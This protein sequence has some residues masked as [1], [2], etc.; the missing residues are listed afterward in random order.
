MSITVADDSRY[1]GGRSC[2]IPLQ[3]NAIKEGRY[4]KTETNWHD[5]Y[6]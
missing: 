6:S 3:N 2:K 1:F 5:G 4:Y